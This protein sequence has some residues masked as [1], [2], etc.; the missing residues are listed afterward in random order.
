MMMMMTN[1]KDEASLAGWEG[2]GG[3]LGTTSG[4]TVAPGYA[5][6]LPTLPFRY[7]AQPAWGFLDPTGRYSYELYRVYAPPEFLRGR[8]EA[9]QLDENASYWVVTWPERSDSGD[10]Y[11]ASRWITYA[12]ARELLGPRLKFYKFCSL[13]YMRAELP[14]LLLGRDETRASGQPE[15]ATGNL[16]PAYMALFACGLALFACGNTESRAAPPPARPPVA[17]ELDAAATP[18]TSPFAAKMPE[19]W[20]DLRWGMSVKQVS[21]IMKRQKWAPGSPPWKSTPAPDGLTILAPD[22][23]FLVVAPQT[24]FGCWSSCGLEG[25]NCVQAW[26]LDGKLVEVVAQAPHD[27]AASA[28]ER[29]ATESYGANP[30]Q[31]RARIMRLRGDPN[32]GS[33]F[34]SDGAPEHELLLWSGSATTAVLYES[35]SDGRPQVAVWS[36]EAMPRMWAALLEKE[37]GDKAAADRVRKQLEDATRF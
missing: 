24:R 30:R 34:P 36:G 15:R 6:G 19:G 16:A 2:E 23:R 8:G 1:P 11:P 29:R 13:G 20:R 27:I 7:V 28:F 33:G 35:I 21:A 26:F 25:A 22:G 10:E 14:E 5:S 17:V 4:S 9:A 37:A 12:R 31:M 18:A 32:G 3:S